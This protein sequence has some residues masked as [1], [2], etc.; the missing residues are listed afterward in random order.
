[1]VDAVEDRV[2][3]SIEKL[4]FLVQPSLS[5]QGAR[6]TVMVVYNT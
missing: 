5:V 6:G 3:S 4:G 2:L 1:M